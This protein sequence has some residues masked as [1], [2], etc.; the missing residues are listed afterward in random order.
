MTITFINPA[1][2]FQRMYT[3]NDPAGSV[4][5]TVTQTSATLPYSPFPT[6]LYGI[7]PYT[8]SIATN[9][10]TKTLPTGLSI[11]NTQ[12]PPVI[13]GSPSA[14]FAAANFTFTI[15][16]AAG[17][18]LSDQGQQSSLNIAVNARTTGTPVSLTASYQIGDTL[19]SYTFSGVSGGVA[20]YTYSYTGTLPGGISLDTSTGILSGTFTTVQTT[21]VV[22]SVTDSNGVTA[23][24]TCSRSFTVVAE[25]TSTLSNITTEALTLTA[26]MTSY[27]PI[28]ALSGG[29]SPY[30]Y[31]IT[32]GT[33]PTG[34]TLNSSTGLV[35]GTPTA[36][37]SAA[38][39]TFGYFDSRVLT[40]HQ[41]QTTTFSAAARTTATADNTGKT[42]TVGTAIT[43]YSPLSAVSNGVSPYNYSI[44]SGT[45]PAGLS[46]GSGSGGTGIVSGTPT[47]AGSASVTFSVSDN[48]GVA[49]ATTATEAFTINAVA[50]PGSQSYTTPGTFTFTVTSAMGGFISVVC[51][52]GGGGVIATSLYGGGGGGGGLVYV[53]NIAV[54]VGQTFTVVVGVA[55]NSSLSTGG[56][57]TF[58][59]STCSALAGGGSISSGIGQN[60]TGG[61]GGGAA[62]YAGNGGTGGGVSGGTLTGGAGGFGSFSGT[63]FNTGSRGVFQGGQ[64][65]TGS[66]LQSATIAATLPSGG[67]GG[68]GSGGYNGTVTGG[69]VGLFG[70]TT[71]DS[72]G[73]TTAP[74]TATTATGAGAVV[75]NGGSGGVDG[76]VTSGGNYGGGASGSISSNLGGTGAVRIMWP[77]NTRLFPST[78]AGTP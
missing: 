4:T 19:S 20:P 42:Y 74:G 34:V 43:S 63:G 57:S 17:N 18:T 54:N 5:F 39:V 70:E 36:T 11:D 50:T 3:Q 38:A 6:L 58:S 44:T 65:G 61:G 24:S 78:S 21:S 13:T 67:G 59:N 25:L 37:K 56:A 47:T 71:V 31:I 28:A 16:D 76:A 66:L 62:G 32:S 35:S 30:T 46:Y 75:H 77:G 29:V 69:G 27:T 9:S 48:N 15:T 64:G 23:A 41:T 22:I 49:A 51:V 1:I 45:L 72:G 2:E 73:F 53:N 60:Q 26:A 10:T 14:T 8:M 55:G 33:L 7:K 12:S 52:G 68:G 40:A